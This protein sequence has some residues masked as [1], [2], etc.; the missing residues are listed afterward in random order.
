MKFPF[1]LS[2]CHQY[3]L[4]GNNP[5]L[6]QNVS[7]LFYFFIFI[8]LTFI[9]FW[10]TERQS[11]SGAGAEREGDTESE[12]DSR[13][14]AISPEPD[15]GLKLRDREIVTWA[16]VGRLTD[17]ATQAPLSSLFL[18]NFGCCFV[19]LFVCLLCLWTR[20]YL[21]FFQATSVYSF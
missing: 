5:C 2:K 19:C 11:M 17:W 21:Y 13:L 15:A 9:Y 20:G 7:I 14:W 10:D 1:F 18:N 6:P 16:E 8:F 12:A 4:S 3:T